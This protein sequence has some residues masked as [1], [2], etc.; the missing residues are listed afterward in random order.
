MYIVRK[1]NIYLTIIL[2]TRRDHS[3]DS[4]GDWYLVF[5]ESE[6][7]KKYEDFWTFLIDY[8]WDKN[9]LLEDKVQCLFVEFKESFLNKQYLFMNITFFLNFLT[10]VYNCDGNA[11]FDY[12][13]TFMGAW[14]VCLTWLR[15]VQVETRHSSSSNEKLKNDTKKKKKKLFI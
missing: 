4:L 7:I 9:Y 12:F 10:K 5:I 6:K 2:F 8:S 15:R 11:Y 14:V 3:G 1:V 13:A